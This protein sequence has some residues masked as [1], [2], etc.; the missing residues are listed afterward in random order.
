MAARSQ[1]LSAKSRLVI[2]YALVVAL[3][4]LGTLG[5]EPY[6]DS[7]FFKRVAL[8]AWEHGAL[9]WNPSDGPV[10]GIT[11]QLFQ[12]VSLAVTAVVP[13]FTVFA[14][15]LVLSLCLLAAFALT[16]ST[17]Y[18]RDRGLA[19]TLACC[20]PLLLFSVDSGMETALAL[21]LIALCIWLLYGEIGQ[22]RHWALAPVVVLLAW[23]TRPDVV[24]LLVPPLLT[25]RWALRGRA[26]VREVLLLALGFGAFLLFFKLYY[27]TALPLA[28]YAKERAFSPY[29]AT[30][31]QAS[32]IAQHWHWGL[33]AS[34]ALPLVL[35]ALERRD[36]TN[37]TLLGAALLFVAY[38]AGTTIDVM[39]MHGRFYAPA[40][41]LLVLAAARAGSQRSK[42]ALMALSYLLIM[43]ALALV[44]FLPGAQSG[45]ERVPLPY[46][47]AS[48]LGALALLLGPAFRW[49]MPASVAPLLA[50]SAVAV[51]FAHGLRL[52]A[53]P[54]DD[55]YL[56]IHE[57]HVT[58]YRGLE[59]LR[60]CVGDGISLY[61]SEVGL[62]GLRFARGKVTDL[63][64]LFNRGWLFREYDFDAMCQRDRPE[65]IFLPHRNYAALNR[66]IVG[67]K[68]LTGYALVVPESSS[69]LYVRKDLLSLYENC[70]VGE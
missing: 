45:F 3:F 65:A 10:Y 2:G 8:N 36:R 24:L 41:L 17:S 30:F 13:D 56:R 31:V 67:S 55:D 47:A 62:P 20:S 49:A 40:S 43:A 51:V 61:H 52:R 9:S 69:P 34:V 66:E 15:R 4:V 14:T 38:H 29:D 32:T 58:V 12:L 16:L 11:S 42:P 23:L 18:G 44:N 63:A 59:R 25:R 6:D 68:C 39:G 33:F 21:A 22:Q 46:Y 48:G 50:A 35:V 64:G 1:A 27:G 54:R 53:P 37:L 57:S 26:P 60:A 5:R 7:Y 19:A 28:F 70:S